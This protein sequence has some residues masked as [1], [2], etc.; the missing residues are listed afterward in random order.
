M[1]LRIRKARHDERTQLVQMFMRAYEGLERYG[2][3]S[4]GEGISYL[5]ELYR[6]CAEGFLIAETPEGI[7][8]FLSADPDWPDPKHGRVLEIHELVVDPKWQGQ[9]VA[10]ALMEAALE[11]GRS[12][13]RDTAGLWVGLGNTY[14]RQWYEE[15]GFRAE[16]QGGEWIRM[17]RSLEDISPRSSG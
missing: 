13:G 8:G 10:T 15:A 9:G 11:L 3:R 16:G 1:Q 2:E 7:A 6:D 12:R 14:A 5:E 4:R 17:R